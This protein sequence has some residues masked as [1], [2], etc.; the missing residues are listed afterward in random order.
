[1]LFTLEITA[2]KQ[3]LENFVCVF[4]NSY[5]P[6]IFTFSWSYFLNIYAHEFDNKKVKFGPLAIEDKVFP[7]IHFE[8]LNVELW[9]YVSKQWEIELWMWK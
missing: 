6:F 8:V 5:F 9:K 4:N 2:R 7:Y 3:I 1:M